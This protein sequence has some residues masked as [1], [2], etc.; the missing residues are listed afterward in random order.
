MEV[1]ENTQKLLFGSKSLDQHTNYGFETMLKKLK[2]KE[3]E[4]KLEELRK[5]RIRHVVT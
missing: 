3:P 4:L 2:I 5:K 1:L